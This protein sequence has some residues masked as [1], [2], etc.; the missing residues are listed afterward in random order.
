[1]PAPAPGTNMASNGAVRAQDVKPALSPILTKR[2]ADVL[3][4]VEKLLDDAAQTAG[5][6]PPVDPAKPA[7]PVSSTSLP[8]PESFAAAAPGDP[9]KSAPR[10]N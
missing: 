1:L 7:K 4:H 8:F 6:T 9:A 10:K 5:N 2:G 3:V